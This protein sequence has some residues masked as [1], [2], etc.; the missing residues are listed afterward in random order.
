MIDFGPFTLR[1]PLLL[2]PL[3]GYTDSPFR[4]IASSCGAGL[5]VT[6]L[7]SSEGIVRR[8]EKSLALMKISDAERPVAIQ[9]FGNSPEVMAEAARIAEELNPDAIDINMGCPAPKICRGGEGGGAA[10]L[11]DP[12]LAGKIA[13][14]VVRAVNIPVTAKIRLGWDEGS[15]NY[16][17]ILNALEGSGVRALFVHGRTRA[18]KYTGRADWDSIA[19]ICRA[20][21]IPVAGNGDISSHEEAHQR[22]ISSG[23]AAV[24]IGRGALGNPWIFSGEKPD[25]NSVREMMIS[26]LDL[27]IE[28]F[29]DWGIT[30]MRKHFAHYIRGFRNA[31]LLRSRLVRVSS[32]E[33]VF[34]ILMDETGIIL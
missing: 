21:K 1:S 9:L 18:Q 23:C 14:A 30:C 16:L 12:L 34:Q 32:R 22:M 19:E 10:L 5:T 6:E 8:G 20:S 33:D 24:M 27:M 28:D 4:K 15:K 11:T 3:A 7:V 25:F 17:E 29:G 13:A 31:S 26:H 2:A